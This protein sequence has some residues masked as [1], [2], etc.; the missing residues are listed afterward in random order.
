MK[1]G[2]MLLRHRNYFWI[3][4]RLVLIKTSDSPRE[5]YQGVGSQNLLRF[6][7]V[8]VWVGWDSENEWKTNMEAQIIE[9]YLNNKHTCMGGGKS[10]LHHPWTPMV[11]GI[12]FH[13]FHWVQWKSEN[14]TFEYQ[15]HSTSGPICVWFFNGRHLVYTILIS[16]Q[17]L[18]GPLA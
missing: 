12:S 6:P 9:K 8:C 7:G 10:P 17:F 13:K 16:V 2:W 14:Q 11:T 3:I 5:F 15:K 18:K 1:W 4:Q